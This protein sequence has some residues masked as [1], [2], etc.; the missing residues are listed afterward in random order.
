MGA[1]V[2][3]SERMGSALRFTGWRSAPFGLSR[4]PRGWGFIRSRSSSR[5][6]TWVQDSWTADHA[7]TN[8]DSV[9]DQ[10][11]SVR[12]RCLPASRRAIIRQRN[13]ANGMTSTL[14]T[15]STREVASATNGAYSRQRFPSRR[16]CH[17]SSIASAAAVVTNREPEPR[18]SPSKWLTRLGMAHRASLRVFE[19]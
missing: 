1:R 6:T 13:S 7:F 17:H 14:A 15:P 3:T 9:S 18:W 11:S 8:P 4:P 12:L 19:D 5:W 10:S 16:Y 2:G